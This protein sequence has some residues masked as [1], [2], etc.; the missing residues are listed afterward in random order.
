MDNHIVLITGAAKGIGRHLAQC[1]L[2]KKYQVIATEIDLNLLEKG[3]NTE[4][5]DLEKLDATKPE[6]WLLLTEKVPKN[7]EKIR[8]IR[9]LH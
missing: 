7:T 4:G 8:K 5:A 2:Q 1:F 3:W 9:Y 6:D